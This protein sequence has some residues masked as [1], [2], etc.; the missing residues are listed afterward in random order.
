MGEITAIEN[1]AIKPESKE[2]VKQPRGKP[3]RKKAPLGSKISGSMAEPEIIRL[4]SKGI[5]TSEIIKYLQEHLKFKVS[6][7]TLNKYRENFITS[8]HQL[9]TQIAQSLRELEETKKDAATVIPSSI[10]E[11]IEKKR[12]TIERIS[13]RVANLER[14]QEDKY[15]VSKEVMIDKYLNTQ[16]TLESYIE[17]IMMEFQIES[18]LSQM[19]KRFTTV[20][21]DAFLSFVPPEQFDGIINNFKIRIMQEYE[22]IREKIYRKK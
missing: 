12:E 10:L 15:S 20:T 19:F 7:P 4:I 2:I 1:Q 8:N 18:L 6:P 14:M 5:S 13:K 3:G 21:F 17:K 16:H 22:Q 9:Q 11:I